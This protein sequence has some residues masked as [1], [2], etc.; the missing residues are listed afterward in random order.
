[1]KR[2][3][4]VLVTLACEYT[5]TARGILGQIPRPNSESDSTRVGLATVLLAR[6]K[7]SE[8]CPGLAG[9]SA[10]YKAEL[11]RLAKEEEAEHQQ[12]AKAASAVRQ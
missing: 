3:H 4:E 2:L 5:Y 12:A 10:E 7:A 11:E 1:M 8:P 6:M 9:L